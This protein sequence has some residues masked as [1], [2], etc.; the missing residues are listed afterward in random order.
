MPTIFR[1]LKKHNVIIVKNPFIYTEKYKSGPNI[2][3]A[4]KKRQVR[5][6]EHL[7]S[8][9]MDE[10]ITIDP[11]AEATPVYIKK[12]VK[13]VE[14]DNTQLAEFLRIHNDNELNGGRIFKEVDVEKE[15]LYEIEKYEAVDSAKAN[16]MKADDNT[17]RAAAV[18]FLNPS[19]IDK[20]PSTL[21]IKLRQNVEITTNPTDKESF[22]SKIN[23]FFAEKNNNEK[24]LTTIALNENIIKIVNGKKIAWDDSNEVI[25][26]AGQ[27]KDVIQ[28][29]A[30]WLKTDEEGR[31]MLSV[32]S[33]KIDKLKK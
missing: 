21:K 10:Q 30:V 26:V 25:Y 19:Y 6:V 15:E 7:D 31:Q 1:T 4:K 20:S 13:L 32:L 12:G 16:I 29:F 27:T 3:K 22:V 14:D 9:F 28:D 2:G 5:Y 11:K 17:L 23:A 24:L 8:I 18:F 33:D